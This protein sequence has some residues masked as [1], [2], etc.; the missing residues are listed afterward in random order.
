MVDYDIKK[1]WAG[2]IEGEGLEK[3]MTETFGNAHKKGGA[4][5]SKYG[6]LEAIEAEMTSKS[7]LRVET[8]NVS[9]PMTDDDILDTKRKLN[10]FV[11]AATGFDVKA[12]KKRAQDKAKKG[13]L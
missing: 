8:A 13:L 11:E 5:V 1:G 2:K 3:L 7:I 9:G 10:A 6:V 12:R 4:I